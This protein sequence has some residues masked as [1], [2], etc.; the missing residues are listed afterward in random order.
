MSLE[1]TKENVDMFIQ[2]L[3]EEELERRCEENAVLE[4]LRETH[5]E[6]EK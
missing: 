6:V 3:W 5:K 4:E 2:Y 1:T